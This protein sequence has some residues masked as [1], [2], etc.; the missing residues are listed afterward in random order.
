MLLVNGEYSSQ[1][2]CDHTELVPSVRCSGTWGAQIDGENTLPVVK[3]VIFRW[4]EKLF[5]NQSIK[6][7]NE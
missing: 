6:K 4:I 5:T 1:K 3:N 7:S 2:I